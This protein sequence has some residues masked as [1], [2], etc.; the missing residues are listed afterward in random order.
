MG[1]TRPEI[2]L[3][4]TN[5]IGR[6]LNTVGNKM[7]IAGYVDLARAVK[8]AQLSLKH[9]QNKNQKQR[10]VAFIGSPLENLEDKDMVKLGKQLRKNDVALDVVNFGHPENIPLLNKLIE[11]C[12]KGGNSNLVE[13]NYG[14]NICDSIITSPIVAYDN[15]Y[16]DMQVDGG[17]GAP[18]AP[19]GAP[20]SAPA[21]PGGGNFAEYGGIDPNLDPELAMAIRI[22]LEEAKYK[23]GQDDDGEGKNEGDKPAETPGQTDAQ[24]APARGD[25]EMENAEGNEAQEEDD[26]QNDYDEELEAAKLLSMQ[27]PENEGDEGANANDGDK[28]DDD[29]GGV[30]DEEFIGEIMQDLG[31]DMTEDAVKTLLTDDKKKDDDNDKKN[32]D[33]K[34]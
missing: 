21:A 5:D 34:E 24:P 22:S 26:E 9:R 23:G 11:N 30:I 29:L 14:S 7:P 10:I 25:A 15:G 27:G 8:I 6:L 31:V 1:G 19:G 2:H 16:D 13:I 4:Q 28:A 20:G 33:K 3:T 17:D 18:A 12:S 32:E